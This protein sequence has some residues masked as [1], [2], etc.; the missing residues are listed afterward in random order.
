MTA[1]R[2]LGA[3]ESNKVGEMRH[4]SSICEDCGVELQTGDW[5][6]C[7]HGRSTLAVV[8]DDVPGA[9]TV[10]NGFTEPRTFYSRSAHHAALAAENC[11]Q[12]A[13]W[14]LGDKHLTRWDT[15]DL[16]A[17]RE[18]VTPRQKVLAPITVSEG[19]SFRE[20]D[21]DGRIQSHK[22]TNVR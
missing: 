22:Y 9:F 13:Y 19:E 21:L 14:H 5:P 4:T 6:F 20:R 16:D 7:P 15:V 3:R 10:E 18:L 1:P 2:A 11:E 17:A 12:R 8:A